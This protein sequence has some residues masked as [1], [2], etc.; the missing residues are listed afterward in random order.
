MKRNKEK[1]SIKLYCQTNSEKKPE[2]NRNINWKMEAK[3]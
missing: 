1:K 3:W 2:N